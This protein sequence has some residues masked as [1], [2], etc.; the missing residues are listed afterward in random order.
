MKVAH[1]ARDLAQ[2]SA[3]SETT[4]GSVLERLYE[5][6]IV[7]AVDPAPGSSEARYEIFHDRLAVPI[8]DWRQQRENARLDRARQRAEQEADVQR[9]QARRFK[10]R[11][12]IMFAL[13]VGL[14]AL[15]VAV[16]VLLGYARSQSDTAKREKTAALRG[17]AE[18]TYFG[19]TARAQSQ[20][21]TRP[22][23][24]N[25]N[26]ETVPGK[27]LAVAPRRAGMGL[28]EAALEGSRLRL[29]PILMTSFAFVVGM[30]PL[31]FTKGASAQGNHSIGWSAVGGML[32]GVILGVF[33]VP[34]LFIIFQYLQEKFF[35][36]KK[37]EQV[38][39]LAE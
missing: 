12:R 22:D 19:L 1:T 38:P 7:R 11:A 33:I 10:R 8:L 27:G 18:A 29:R 37:Y 3:H 36:K 24:L 13:A 35:G 28:V 30:L 20:L 31:I 32:T 21:S 26:L 25:H 16:V 39:A 4:V 23:V 6:R 34:V 14:L 2:M 17:T 9:T 15:L 5:E